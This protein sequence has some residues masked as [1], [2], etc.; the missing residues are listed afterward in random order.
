MFSKAFSSV[1]ATFAA[2]NINEDNHELLH[3]EKQLHAIHMQPL[4]EQFKQ[5]FDAVSPVELN[6]DA[7]FTFFE[8]VDKVI[9]HNSQ[10][11]KSFTKAL[12]KF[13]G[14]NFKQFSDYTHLRDNQENA[15]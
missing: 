8:N 5:E 12:N 15:E 3:G 4:W 7:M 13:S 9:E 10:E 11:N 1:L 14:M 6:Q 2:A